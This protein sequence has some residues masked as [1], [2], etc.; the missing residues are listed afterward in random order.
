M[1]SIPVTSN[2]VPVSRSDIQLGVPIP[3][4]VYDRSGMLLLKAGFK[5]NLERH[6]GVLLQNGLY[7]DQATMITPVRPRESRPAAPMA[8]EQQSTFELVETI[9]QRLRHLFEY[10]RVGREHD[11][12]LLRVETL[13]ITVQEA[14][15]HDTDAVLANLNLDYEMP[16]EVIHHL[17]AAVLC[18]LIG[19]RLGVD[20]AARSSLVLAAL[21][22]DIGLLDVQDLLDRQATPLTAAQKARITA[23]P[24]ESVQVLRGLGVRDAAWLDAVHH[25]HERID[26]SGYPD[27][28]VG[29]AVRSPAR[30]LA[31]AD[32]Y[33]AMVRDR[34]YRKAIVS[35]LAMRELMLAEGQRID[36]R[37]TQAMIKEIGV[38]PPGVLV[39][40]ANG[41]TAVVKQRLVNSA[42]PIVCS[43]IKPD[44]MPMLTLLR[45]E[46][47]RPEFGIEGI[48][49]FSQYRGS[50]SLIR[51][52]WAGN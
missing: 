11:A 21:T 38:F 4:S 26:G 35:R 52:L 6:L 2:L 49:P 17:L 51:S 29:D 20:E 41:E 42:S 34:P 47:T 18:E 1:S 10:F 24:L 15:T 12:F 14:C 22:H 39:K 3:H 25:H 16:Y 37:L 48:V 36:Q 45:R 32:V 30:V 28:L 13:G 19:K 23:H 44:G 40:L 50:V 7:F 8:E 5:I 33:S 9:K 46:T 31:V 43:F 27:G